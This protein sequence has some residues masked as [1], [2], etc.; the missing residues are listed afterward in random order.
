MLSVETERR[1]AKLLVEIGRGEGS[2][3]M[4]RQFLAKEEDYS[5][6]ACFLRI[7]RAHKGWVNSVDIHNFLRDNA[8]LALRD[9]Q[10]FLEQISLA[11]V[12]EAHH[13]DAEEGAEQQ[14]VYVQRLNARHHMQIQFTR[15]ELYAAPGIHGL[16]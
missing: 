7:D 1:L 16:L 5:P 14:G 8:V 11:G 13:R 4:E 12:D 3:E 2:L 9:Q 6:Y 10:H 15:P